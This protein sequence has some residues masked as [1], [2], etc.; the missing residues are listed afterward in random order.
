MEC[1]EIA[2][3]ISKD[4]QQNNSE[5]VTTENDKEILRERDRCPE[6]RDKFIDNLRSNILV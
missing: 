2:N 1:Q 3:I 6:E 4:S 5:A